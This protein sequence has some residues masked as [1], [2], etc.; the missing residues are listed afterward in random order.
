MTHGVLEALDYLDTSWRLAFDR[1]PLLAL[2]TAA[3]TADLAEPCTN[4]DEFKAR[5]SAVAEVLRAIAIP[6]ERLAEGDSIPPDHTLARLRSC[7]RRHLEA[8]E[9]E[10]AEEAAAVLTA[11]TRV[12]TGLQ[13]EAVATELPGALERLGV[14]YP[15]ADWGD[16]WDE[17][18]S[19][20]AVAVRN[21]AEVV[22]ALAVAD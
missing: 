11:A 8:E 5:M 4:L 1:Q 21:L 12:R 16:A 15:P 14:T 19:R 7:L 17:V 6:D 10:R 3:G 22:R 20:L 13:H 9:Y 18:R 2:R